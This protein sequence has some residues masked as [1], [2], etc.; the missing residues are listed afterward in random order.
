MAMLKTAEETGASNRGRAIKKIE[1]ILFKH[2]MENVAFD[3]SPS[4]IDMPGARHTRKRIAI[5]METVD[6]A[7]GEYV[8]GRPDAAPQTEFLARWREIHGE[9]S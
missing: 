1:V 4:G 2:D 5:T 6:G 9:T 3:V 7:R 8:G